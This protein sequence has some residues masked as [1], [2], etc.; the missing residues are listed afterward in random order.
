MSK[1]DEGYPEHQTL[2]VGV[3]ESGK[4]VGCGVIEGHMMGSSIGLCV[5]DPATRRGFFGHYI[6][7]T[8]V[9][10]DLLETFLHET[11]DAIPDLST[12]RVWLGGGELG[13][14]PGTDHV[15]EDGR[16]LISARVHETFGGRVASIRE[17]WLDMPGT[18]S[19]SLDVGNGEESIEIVDPQ[20]AGYD[21]FGGDDD[22]DEELAIFKEEKPL[23]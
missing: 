6:A 19:Y 13:Y 21:E 16:A 1:H 3:L 18:I 8:I 7:D 14:D 23:E 17:F 20:D 22:L 15:T 11:T 4:Q 10:R 5:Y 12:A 2:E 9:Y